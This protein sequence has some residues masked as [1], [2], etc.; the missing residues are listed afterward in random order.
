MKPR[1]RVALAGTDQHI[2]DGVNQD[3]LGVSTMLLAQQVFTPVTLAARIQQRI[4]ANLA[5]GVAKAAWLKAIS[6]YEAIDR[7][8][9]IIVRDFR[10]VVIGAF[11]EDSDK[12]AHYGF[13]PDRKPVWS[14]ET[15]ALAAERRRATRKA[16]GT[17]GPK[18][19]LA[20]KGAVPQK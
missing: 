6:D 19:K 12:L 14:E 5:I 3:L 2:I 18:A 20:V 10:Q 15:K 17:M 8:T 7:V 4:D 13:V 1:N 9:D 11:G 16:R